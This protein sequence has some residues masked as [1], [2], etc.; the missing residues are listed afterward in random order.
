[1]RFTD[2][3]WDFDG[4]LFDSYEHIYASFRNALAEC[5]I[6]DDEQ[7]MR[8]HVV[9]S[10]R[11]AADHYRKEFGAPD[12]LVE[13]Y[14]RWGS[15]IEFAHI[16]PYG[17]AEQVLAKIVESGRRNHMYTH[18]GESTFAYLD[19][20]GLRQYMTQIIT[21][22]DP[23]PPKPDPGA[24]LHLQATQHIEA[25][26]MLMVGDRE[27]DLLASKRAGGAGCFF[28]TNN[29]PVPTCADFTIA[30]LLELTVHL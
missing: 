23:F 16:R 7:T 26:R 8:K 21:G 2:I 22:L 1:M 27:I 30:S 4:T 6:T 24:L 28:N 13:I 15:R 19:H 20:Y 10:V 17:G 25:S 18:R 14:Q 12:N 11:E 29:L 3:V 5:G 9:V